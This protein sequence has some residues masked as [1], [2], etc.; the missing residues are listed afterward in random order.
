MPLYE[1]AC[2]KCGVETSAHYKIDEAVAYPNCQTCGEQMIRMYNFG[3][4]S[5]KGSGFYTTDKK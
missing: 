3:S 1:F 5:F 4:V 2:R